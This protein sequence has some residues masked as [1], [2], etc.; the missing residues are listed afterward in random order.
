MG[1]RPDADADEHA[2]ALFVPLGEI[3]RPVDAGGQ[4]ELAGRVDHRVETRRYRR[5]VAGERHTHVARAGSE[6]RVVRVE[7]RQN[8]VHRDLLAQDRRGGEDAHGESDE[9]G[10]E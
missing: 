2:D 6:D 4:A 8:V 5:L 9:G 10:N 7:Q 3:G 1:A